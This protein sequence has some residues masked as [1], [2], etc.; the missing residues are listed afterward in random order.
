MKLVSG[1]RLPA[2]SFAYFNLTVTDNLYSRYKR[3]VHLAFNVYAV[4][5]E[6]D[7]DIY[8]SKTAHVNTLDKASWHSAR[9][10]S[11]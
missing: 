4:G 11:D 6:S 3:G 2:K 1:L 10:G 8:L 9:E 5:F 7:P